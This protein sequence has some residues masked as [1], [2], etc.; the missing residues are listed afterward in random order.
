MTGA[1]GTGAATTADC[2]RCGTPLERGDLRCAICGQAAPA[3][4][5]RREAVVVRMLRCRGCDAAISYDPDV[6]APR[7]SFCGSVLELEEREDPEEEVELWLPFTVD[8]AAAKAALR[9][10]LGRQ[11]FFRPSDL[12]SA[13]RVEELQPLYWVAWCFDATALV[14]WTADSNAGAGRAAWAPYAGQVE[15]VFDDLLVSA[16]RGLSAGETEGLASSYD[17]GTA[18]ERP[19]GPEGA[20]Q[21]RFDVQRSAARRR[22]ASAIRAD[23]GRRVQDRCVPGSRVRNLSTEVLLRRL[24]TRR[25]ALPAW[26]LAY[27]YRERLYRVVVSGQDAG[28]VLGD[29]PRSAA[30]VALVVL[31]AVVGA[32]LLFALLAL[33]LGVGARLR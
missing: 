10:W 2:A 5:E 15:L 6:Q 4:T 31:A 24:V 20:L 23:A 32:A 14:S 30:K 17:L 16:S 21:E 1:D 12:R 19:Q 26:V 33:A 28:R 27:R 29:A 13:S 25:H 11:G 18:Y 22:I 8:A 9:E 3:R 7:C